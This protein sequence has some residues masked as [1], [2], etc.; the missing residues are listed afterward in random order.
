MLM[1]DVTGEVVHRPPQH[2]DDVQRLLKNFEDYLHADD[3]LDPLVRMVFLHHQFEIIH[4]FMDGNGRTRTHLERAFLGER[5]F[6][7]HADSLF[8]GTSF[9]RRRSIISSC[10]RRGKPATMKHGCFICSLASKKPQK[11]RLSW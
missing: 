7:V 5:R 8:V 4:P 9:A 10:S 11:R 6:A 2:P 1:N 3:E